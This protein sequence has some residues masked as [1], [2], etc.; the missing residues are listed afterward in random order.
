[1]ENVWGFGIGALMLIIFAG[2]MAYWAVKSK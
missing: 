1:M 2:I